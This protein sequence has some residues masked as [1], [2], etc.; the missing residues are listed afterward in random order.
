MVHSHTVKILNP[1]LGIALDDGDTIQNPLLFKGSI[2]LASDFPT[3]SEVQ[4][5]WFYIISAN[6]TDNDVTKTNTGQSFLSG[7]EVVWNGTNWSV[8][9][10]IEKTHN[11]LTGIQ[12]GSSNQYYHMTS[13]EYT[14]TGSNNFVRQTSPTLTTPI[15]NVGSDATGDIYYRSA[16]GAFTRLPIG[17]AG[18]NLS[19]S[20]GIPAWTVPKVSQFDCTVGSSGADYT[21]LLDAYNAGKNHML[22]ITDLSSQAVPVNIIRDITITGLHPNITMKTAGDKWFTW[23]TTGKTIVFRNLTFTHFDGVPTSYFVYLSQNS[24]IA[25]FENCTFTRSDQFN[26]N[27][28]IIRTSSVTDFAYFNNCTFNIG[29]NAYAFRGF[30]FFCNNCRFNATQSTNSSITHPTAGVDVLYL[31]NCHFTGNFSTSIA[32]IYGSNITINNLR[33]YGTTTSGNLTF[34]SSTISN[35][36]LPSNCTLT[37]NDN[38]ISNMKWGGTLTI[39]GDRNLLTNND[40]VST[41]T[42][43]S[44]S[45]LNQISNSKII[46]AV[47]VTGNNTIITGCRVGADAG[48]G[49]ATITFNSGATGCVASSNQVDADISDSGTSTQLMNNYTY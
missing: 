16:G 24:I 9:G 13:A 5:G 11:Q 26:A 39:T 38:T 10:S 36:S 23:N 33:Y 28:N 7:D 21:N 45:D 12:G 35:S 34:S 27:N 1:F 41:L 46:G 14:G 19:V 44:G 3:S 47:S 6:V 43:G 17:T 25:Y 37:G 31:N 2:S 18:Y 4:N 48:G 15:I 49:T 8:L 32:T 22:V 42:I 29:Y 40:V 20:A 30:N